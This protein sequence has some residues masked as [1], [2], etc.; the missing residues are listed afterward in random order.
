MTT[1][2]APSGERCGHGGGE[3]FAFAG[4]HLCDTA[5]VHGKGGGNLHEVRLFASLAE[6]DFAHD[7]QGV[8]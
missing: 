7:S 5:V 8:E 2:A 4:R 1:A 6:C 3:R